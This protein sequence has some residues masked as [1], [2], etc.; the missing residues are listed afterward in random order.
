MNLDALT[1]AGTLAISMGL[2]FLASARIWQRFAHLA[3]TA[4]FF[5]EYAMREAAQRFRDEADLLRRNQAIYLATLLTACLIFAAALKLDIRGLYQ[6]YPKWQLAIV[7]ALLGSLASYLVYKAVATL[8]RLGHTRFLRD[9]NMAIGHQLQ[10]QVTRR[11]CVYHEVEVGRGTIDHVLVGLDG[12]Y[13]VHVIARRCERDDVANLTTEDLTLGVETI[14]L[15][16]ITK[17]VQRLSRIFS[18]LSSRDIQV[19]SVIA[20]PGWRIGEQQRDTHLL[21]NE[22]TLPQ[23]SEWKRAPGQLRHEDV[24]T[25]QRF[26]GQ[27]GRPA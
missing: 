3:D 5:P 11:G 26:L 1:T 6:G 18:N 19:H 16:G 22:H 21:V 14:Q 17:S 25:I 23:L 24:A 27:R 2:L 13:A 12:I 10:Q 9:A 4:P 7:A 8:I 15:A 20:I